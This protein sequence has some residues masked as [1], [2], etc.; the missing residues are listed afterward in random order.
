MKK[1][2]IYKVCRSSD[3]VYKFFSNEKV[4]GYYCNIQ[5]D[6]FR[7]DHYFYVERYNGSDAS[8]YA[9]AEEIVEEYD[10]NDDKNRYIEAL[11]LSINE[12]K[13]NS[14]KFTVY[15][16]YVYKV[17]LSMQD[18]EDVLLE[19]N[20]KDYMIEPDGDYKG[21]DGKWLKSRELTEEDLPVLRDS[22]E[23]IKN[24]LKDMENKLDKCKADLAEDIEKENK[25]E[26]KQENE[27]E[28]M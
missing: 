27:E 8:Y 21:P 24:I 9:P 12:I 26:S 15:F 7:N 13:T 20:Y 18:F 14:R 22:Y 6:Y 28:I 10:K 1:D 11:E 3:D 5:N 25:V 2:Y 17:D 4:A 23:N 19:D 16:G